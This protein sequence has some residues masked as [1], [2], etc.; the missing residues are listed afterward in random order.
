MP[1]IIIVFALGGTTMPLRHPDSSSYARLLRGCVSMKALGDGM[2]VH[3]HMIKTGIESDILLLNNLVNMYAKCGS[4]VYARQVFNK[5]IERDSVS[6]NAMIAGYSQSGHGEDALKLFCRM[7]RSNSTPDQFTF[8]SLT[9]ACAS[10]GVQEQGNQVH[11]LTIKTGLELNVYVGSALVDMYSKFHR[12]EDAHQVFDRMSMQDVVSFNSLIAGYAQHGNSREALQL[13]Q[14]LKWV[15]MNPDHITFTSVINAFSKP[16][17]L[18]QGK[19]IHVHIVKTGL[20]RH[21]FVESSLIGMYAK[22]GSMDDARD[23]FNNMTKQ[24]VV[25]WTAMIAGYA[26]TGYGEEALK[27]FSQLQSVNMKPDQ[28]AFASALRACANPEFLEQGKQIHALLVKTEYEPYTAVGCALVTMYAACGSIEDGR[29]AFDQMYPKRDIISWT[30]M[31]SGY[32]QNGHGE[33]AL[34]LFCQM[35]QTNMKPD[36]VTVVSVLGACK[37]L[38][39]IEQ[40]KQ[41]HS[42]IIK[43]GLELDACVGTALL[44]MYANCWSID[45]ARKV[46]SKMA[47]QDVISCGAMIAG[48]AQQGYGEEALRLLCQMQRIGFNPN[49]FIFT[50][51]LVACASLAVLEQGMSVHAQIIKTGFVSDVFVGSALIDMY[52]KC[53]SIEN[54][55]DVFDKMTK[56]DIVLWN[57]MIA[58]YSHH[59]HGNEAL[60]LFKQMQCAGMKPDHIT[61]I[62]VLSACSHVGLVDDGRYYFES[63]SYEHGITPRMEHYACMVDLLGRAGLLHEAVDFIN[64]MPFEPGT[65]VLRTLLGACRNFGNTEL[66]KRTAECLLELEPRDTATYVLLSNIYA[67]AGNWDDVVKLRKLMN[68]RGLIKEPG[69]S[70]IQ[71]KNRMEVFL[72]GDR[73]H[74]QTKEIYAKLEELIEQI[75]RAGYVPNTKFAMHGVE[76]EQKEQSLYYHSE[77]LAVAFGLINTPLGLPIRVIKNLRI[78]GDC[79]TAI[80]LISNIVQHQ[81]VEQEQHSIWPHRDRVAIA[82]R[83]YRTPP[84]V[85]FQVIKSYHMPPLSIIRIGCVLVQIIGGPSIGRFGNLR[86]HRGSSSCYCLWIMSSNTTPA[87]EF[88]RWKVLELFIMEDDSFTRNFNE[89]VPY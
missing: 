70:W 21:I 28:I 24:N 7:Q 42:Y 63:M 71:V 9:R 13:F 51:V 75:K 27:L 23:L 60:K 74:P 55:N 34:K 78:C 66:A 50:S 61:L 22:C 31:L 69:R 30:T 68:E 33:E 40:S 5:M 89:M 62:G 6:W 45:A 53:G 73:M 59:G 76:Q 38:A 54:A 82:F 47:L 36:H 19:Q 25:S 14:Q 72:A 20:E 67:T 3:G 26:Q 44:T 1:H 15:G 84:G 17:A 29:Q 56:V 46:F 48:Y 39:T 11:T 49:E 80:K 37:S 12:I 81:I 85:A 79:H 16:E 43:T 41:L 83:L 57:A 10:L 58:G 86:N 77:K 18:H 32:A 8:A 4:V 87:V 65:V 2:R 52:A 88:F 64:I 35:R